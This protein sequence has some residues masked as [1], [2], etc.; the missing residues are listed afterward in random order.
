MR[1]K[2]NTGPSAHVAR[3][4]PPSEAPMRFSMSL[5]RTTTLALVGLLSFV[6][7]DGR[8]AW[9]QGCVPSRFTSPSLGALGGGGG[10]IYLSAG[11]WQVGFAYRDFHSNQL[12]VGQ[13]VRNDLALG[14]IPS[15]VH[16]Q[17]VNVSLVYGVTD[18]LSVTVNAPV[19]RG[20][21]QL[22]YS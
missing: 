10:D 16:V 22:T 9:A 13:R 11:T 12:I 15:F 20:S 19:S 7:F 3:A 6:A 2:S 18:R 17:S 21:L 14:G 8:I 4:L 5:W 1:R